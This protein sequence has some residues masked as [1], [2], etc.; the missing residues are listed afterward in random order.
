MFSKQFSCF[1]LSIFFVTVCVVDLK[2]HAPTS[3]NNS[4]DPAK[5][6]IGFNSSGASPTTPETTISSSDSTNESSSITSSTDSSTNSMLPETSTIDPGSQSS[7]YSGNSLTASSTT[8]DPSIPNPTRKRITRQPNYPP[9]QP[10]QPSNPNPPPFSMNVPDFHCFIDE[11][12]RAEVEIFHVIGV[13]NFDARFMISTPP[14]QFRFSFFEKHGTPSAVYSHSDITTNSPDPTTISSDST[15]SSDNFA[16]F[17]WNFF[18]KSTAAPETNYTTP[19]N[20]PISKQATLAWDQSQQRFYFVVPD[21]AFRIYTIDHSFY[22]ASMTTDG[23]TFPFSSVPKK[24][25]A[26]KKM[27]SPY[28]CHYN[29]KN[30]NVVCVSINEQLVTVGIYSRPLRYLENRFSLPNYL[31]FD[32]F[33]SYADSKG[34]DFILI[35]HKAQWIYRINYQLY[36]NNHNMFFKVFHLRTPDGKLQFDNFEH[37]DEYGLVTRYSNSDGRYR[38]YYSLFSEMSGLTTYCVH[39]QYIDGRLMILG[40]QR[41]VPVKS[42]TDELRQMINIEKGEDTDIPTMLRLLFYC[43]LLYLFIFVT[44]QMI[45][46]REISIMKDLHHI[47]REIKRYSPVIESVMTKVHAFLEASKRQANKKVE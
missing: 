10:H 32:K 13:R 36:L 4:K 33:F 25:D 40:R 39:D 3:P 11:K 5:R 41:I 35:H 24:A 2:K 6:F 26:S 21:N 28:T 15:T 38:Y 37:A 18:T 46:A 29:V 19:M 14:T 31:S 45:P 12:M 44:V 22:S 8:S 17:D 43:S 1:L 7:S 47:G 20:I 27:T 9:W 34:N 30:Q 16:A 42:F 23:A